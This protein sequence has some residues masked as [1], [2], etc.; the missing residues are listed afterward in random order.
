MA[1]IIE[2][3]IKVM[4]IHICNYNPIVLHTEGGK[5]VDN[6]IEKSIHYSIIEIIS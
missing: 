2:Y 4:L 6:V 1:C 5:T 3:L